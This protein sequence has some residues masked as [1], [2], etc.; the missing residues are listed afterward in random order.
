MENENAKECRSCKTQSC[1]ISSAVQAV[2][3]EKSKLADK[4]ASSDKDNKGYPNL[5]NSIL[6]L[7]GCNVPRQ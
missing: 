5:Q 6:D 2:L 4:P 3:I 1:R 7:E